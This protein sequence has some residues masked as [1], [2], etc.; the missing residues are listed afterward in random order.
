MANNYFNHSGYPANR[1]AG[2][3]AALRAELAA[4]AAGFD[5]LPPLTGNQ[6]KLIAVNASGSGL[7]V[8]AAG[9]PTELNTASAIVMRDGS[10]NFAA[11]TITAAL[12]GNASTATRLQTARNINGVAFD[13]TA[14]ITVADDTKLPLAGGTLTGGLNVSSGNVGIG[15][16]SP[17][18][19]VDVSGPN[20][21]G[22]R[23]VSASGIG[24]ILGDTAGVCAQVGTN[25][26]HPFRV[27]TNAQERMR[28]DASGNVGIGTDDPQNYGGGYRI[29]DLKGAT[30]TE[31]G[32]YQT[33]SSN[34]SVKSHFF[35]HSTLTGI[36]TITA[37]P[38]VIYTNSVERLRIDASGNL[39]VGQTAT[40]LQ[41]SN[42]YHFS[43]GTQQISHVSGT[44]SGAAYVTFGLAGAQIGSITQNGTT[45]VAYNT[46]SDYRLKTDIQPMTGAVASIMNLKP[47]TYR[48]KA[49][50]SE[51]EGFIA[52][53]LQEVCPQA[54]TG[55]KDAV[56][57]QGKPKYQGIDTSF[58]VGRLVAAVQELKAEIDAIKVTLH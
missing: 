13:G 44:A 54:V 5:K 36:N 16:S 27:I 15:T 9:R 32:I 4:I 11:G 12:M 38:F 19:K 30:T 42:S 7:E 1:S 53:E 31:G 56:D 20:G 34:G 45:A 26:N 58:L 29:V 47:V 23:Y 2:S 55:E 18:W 25:T 37:H 40:G 3:S 46:T 57:E 52:H 8:L 10:G 21:N 43:A 17:T 39:L 48:W 14:N 49:D 35:A 33:S 6:L 41:N 51:G 50:G 28:I 22:F 24:T